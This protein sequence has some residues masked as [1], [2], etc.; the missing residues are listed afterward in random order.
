MVPALSWCICVP[1]WIIP[2]KSLPA[3]TAKREDCVKGDGQGKR[4]WLLKSEPS[5]FSYEDLEKAPKRTTHWDGVR[6]Y[7]ARNFLRD[8]MKTGDGVLFY[9]SSAD[10][11]GVAGIAEVAREG[12]PDPSATD[13]KDPHYDPKST[14]A[15][16][17]W[18]VVDIR[19]VRP[20]E[21]FIPLDELRGMKGLEKMSL[22]QKGNRLS[23]QRVTPQEW[24][25][26]L[27][28]AAKKPK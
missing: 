6:N 5:V 25:I 28:A 2:A 10:P 12:Y 24:D 23:V 4:Y 26:I 3:I 22:L 14:A 15:D 16:P 20:L 27:K 7:T 17:I 9:H 1:W 11:A 8:E 13:P 18:Y 21:R 19:A